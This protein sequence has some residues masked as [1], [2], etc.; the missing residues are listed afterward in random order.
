MPVEGVPVKLGTYLVPAGRR[1][2]HN[3][4]ADMGS[5]TRGHGLW[6]RVYVLNAFSVVHHAGV[7]SACPREDHADLWG[8]TDHGL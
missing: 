8:L 2:T 4:M 1:V 3:T 5:Q 7:H 6:H